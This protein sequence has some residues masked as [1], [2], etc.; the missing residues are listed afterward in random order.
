MGVRPRAFVAMPFSV[1]PVP[2]KDGK[3]VDLN[4]DSLYTDLFAPAIRK[5]GCEPF[6]ADEEAS[7]GDIRTDM[8]FELVTAEVVVADISILNANV[9]YELGIRHGIAPR[10]ILQLH[11][12]FTRRP[13]DVAPDRT[14]PYDGTLFFVD[15][16]RDDVWTERLAAE[17][18]ELAARI[19]AALDTDEQTT[20]SPVYKEL[21]GLLPPD[22][23]RIQT[24]RAKYF[25]SELVDWRSRLRTARER[26]RVGDLLTLGRDAP[27]RMYVKELTLAAAQ[28]LVAMRCF[29]I[30]RSVLEDLVQA[31]PDNPAARCELGQVLGR[32]NDLA[33]AEEHLQHAATL[34]AGEAEVHG[35][36]GR[37][38]KSRW[39]LTWEHL[40]QE[41]E[42]REVARSKALLAEDALGAYL[43]ALR[44]DMDTYYNG[45]NVVSL[46]WLLD[47]LGDPYPDMPGTIDE[48]AT[49]TRV[50]ARRA[51]DEPAGTDAHRRAQRIW[52]TA[53]LGEL[54]LISGDAEEAIAR[55]NEASSLPGVTAF[56]VDSMSTQL[57]LYSGLGAHPV[58]VAQVLDVLNPV[59]SRLASTAHRF[60]KV[61]VAS[62]H[63]TDEPGRGKPRFPAEKEDAVREALRARLETWQIGKGDLVVCGAAR[64][65]DIL[66]AEL[67]RDAGAH[68][69]LL[70]ALP[71]GEFV[72]QS[73]A[74]P[75][76]GWEGRFADLIR[77]CET[78][79]QPELLGT[80][81]RG[82]NA[83]QRNN[84]WCL[85][86]ARVHAEEGQ[87]LALVVWDQEPG[88]GTG[89][90]SDFVAEA[91]RVGAEV[92]VVDPTGL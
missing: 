69:R 11:A 52:A 92:A 70:M 26:G 42:R 49:V 59:A 78:W 91:R 18:V 56:Q 6:R 84:V 8:Y 9:F 28:E 38:A 83:F 20:G 43:V 67:C 80:P 73:V 2:T 24:A 7:Q 79:Y 74:L 44:R 89:G 90:T 77:T 57:R 29:A 5:A 13:F 61:L 32:M 48:L 65:A 64:G 87:L 51:A 76:T 63:M 75:G 82:A 46:A 66:V 3:D 36:L 85:D 50:A 14:I 22:T 68:V 10:G 27:N 16:K 31:V 30:A 47:N 35:M 54:A 62:G 12:G 58:A 15:Q 40:A 37:V 53:T 19:R 1:K 41:K 55:Y 45:V 88:D 33:G 25:G 23:S 21:P 39:R 86:T 60:R 72:T 71:R 34:N 17:R 4:F 81:P